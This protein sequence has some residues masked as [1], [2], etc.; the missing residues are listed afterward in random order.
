VR[1]QQFRT[2]W[3]RSWRE[4]SLHINATHCPGVN[5]EAAEWL[6]SKGVFAGVSAFVF[7]ASSLR[8][9]AGTGSPIRRVALATP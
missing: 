1:P 5:R 3:A 4:A 7:A 6:S 9:Q 8:I 2:G